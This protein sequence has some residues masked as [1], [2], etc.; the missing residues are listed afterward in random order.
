MGT[1]FKRPTKEVSY[2]Q[3]L[4]W[5]LSKLFSSD[6]QIRSTLVLYFR[7]FVLNA[8]FCVE[9]S[10]ENPISRKTPHLKYLV[11][12]RNHIWTNP[13]YKLE[14]VKAGCG[15]ISISNITSLFIYGRGTLPPDCFTLGKA[16][17]Q[18][19][20]VESKRD[21]SIWREQLVYNYLFFMY[22]LGTESR[23]V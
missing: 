16:E 13:A 11:L 8:A 15:F 2:L 10:H 6:V 21:E 14:S 23:R 19:E 22:L 3:G 4:V 12:I 17:Q 5:V 18:R 9:K 1:K 7:S 20:T